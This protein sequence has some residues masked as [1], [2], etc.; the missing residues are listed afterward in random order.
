MSTNNLYRLPE[1]IGATLS[2]CPISSNIYNKL[3]FLVPKYFHCALNFYVK[4][5]FA[6]DAT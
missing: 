4:F 2:R 1:K 6:L 5:A 3:I